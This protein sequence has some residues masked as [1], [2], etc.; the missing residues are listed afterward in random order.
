MYELAAEN[1]MEVSPVRSGRPFT[2]TTPL[3]LLWIEPPECVGLQFGIPTLN[4][5]SLSP[6]PKSV[7]PERRTLSENRLTLLSCIWL[8]RWLLMTTWTIS[9]KCSVTLASTRTSSDGM[10]PSLLSMW[11]LPVTASPSTNVGLSS[12]IQTL[13][14][15][16]TSRFKKL[17]SS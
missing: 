6:V 12:V 13:A 5:K 15:I 4:G 10:Y 3:T 8:I 14:F 11:T 17:I 1:P 9:R 16:G 2:A 7:G